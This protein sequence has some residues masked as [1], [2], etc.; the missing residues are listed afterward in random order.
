MSGNYADSATQRN[1]RE[2]EAYDEGRVWEVSNRWHA[3]VGHVLFGPNTLRAEDLF[4]SLMATRAAG[5]AVMDVG[6]GPGTLSMQLHELGARSVYGFDVSRKEVEK[7][8]SAYG[9][10]PGMEFAVH[11]AEAPIEGKFDLIVGRSI[12]HHVDFRAVVTDLFERN[13]S[14]GGRMMF[15]EPM[16]HPLTLLFHRFVRSAHTPDEWPLTPADVRWLQSRFA[17]RVR[18]VNLWSFPAGSISS[19]FLPSPDNALVRLADR[20]DQALERR[21]RFVA[22]GRQ[23]IVVIDR[24][25]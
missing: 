15:M 11:G 19:L 13:L 25:R 14:P 20:V 3:R 23:G 12:L 17:A 24:P 8:R 6:C 16:S 18:P 10:L 21:P 5:N 2:S 22:R 9:S 1:A 4:T 7:A